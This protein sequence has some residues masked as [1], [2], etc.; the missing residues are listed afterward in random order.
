MTIVTTPGSADADSYIT[1]QEFNAYCDKTGRG[2]SGTDDELGVVL[3]KGVA[4]LENAYRG[5]WVGIAAT[6][7]QALAWPRVDGYRTLWRSYTYPLVDGEGFQIAIDAI[8]VQIK[9]A[10]CEASLLAFAGTKL[11]PTL[12]RGGMIKSIGKSVGPLRKD[13]VYMDG[14]PAV[15]RYIAID[16]LLRG[17]VT[18]SPGATSGNVRL[19]R[20]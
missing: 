7:T 18:S 17:L 1:L 20:S 5:R 13:I 14:A 9:N 11:E 16:G 6:Q 8:P 3:H 10:Q 4:Y 15:D 19:V 2:V 12:V